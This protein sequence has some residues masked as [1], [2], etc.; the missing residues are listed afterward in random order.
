MCSQL[1]SV[2]PLWEAFCNPSVSRFILLGGRFLTSARGGRGGI[3]KTRREWR[4]M[5]LGDWDVAGLKWL[6]LR[7]GRLQN[8]VKICP[9]RSLDYYFFL[10]LLFS[11]FTFLFFSP[12]SVS[13]ILPPIFTS[14]CDSAPSGGWGFVCVWRN[15]K[16]KIQEGGK[17]AEQQIEEG[18]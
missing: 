3:K 16:T 14:P 13:L 5:S 6:N 12:L 8:K 10:P 4:N 15:A 18:R 7:P 11:S 1:W 9:P 17:K 2:E